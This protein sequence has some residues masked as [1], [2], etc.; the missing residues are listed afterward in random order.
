MNTLNAPSKFEYGM[1]KQWSMY[2]NRFYIST[3]APLPFKTFTRR[4]SIEEVSFEIVKISIFLQP[5]K[6]AYQSP[7]LLGNC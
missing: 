3:C 7:S 1:K 6:M 5:L 4:S 2:Y